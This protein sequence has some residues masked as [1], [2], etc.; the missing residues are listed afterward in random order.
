[1]F[2]YR[3]FRVSCFH[4]LSIRSD[5]AFVIQITLFVI[6]AIAGAATAYLL[7]QTHAQLALFLVLVRIRSDLFLATNTNYI[8]TTMLLLS[9]YIH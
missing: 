3:I 6:G 4:S 9:Y 5:S 1:M 8:L 2:G 7:L